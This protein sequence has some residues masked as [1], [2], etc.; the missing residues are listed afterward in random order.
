MV[1][2]SQLPACWCPPAFSWW[3]YFFCPYPSD[4][5]RPPL[6]LDNQ[7]C[8]YK[9]HFW[10]STCSRYFYC[11]HCVSHVVLN[12]TLGPAFIKHTRDAQTTTTDSSSL[13]MVTEWPCHSCSVTV[14]LQT[15][16]HRQT[17][18]KVYTKAI[19]ICVHTKTHSNAHIQNVEL[20]P[21]HTLITH[22]NTNH[23]L[24]IYIT[25]QS[26]KLIFTLWIWASSC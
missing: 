10:Q 11:P 17:C 21:T 18:S 8:C 3:P 9:L 12:W 6:P 7:H 26:L 16:S 13:S 23:N 5:W 22:L 19:Y 2:P 24:K 14:T 1:N 20:A 25:W 4:S 15:N